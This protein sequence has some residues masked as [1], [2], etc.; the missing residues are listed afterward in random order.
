M[1]RGD[2]GLDPAGQVAAVNARTGAGLTLLGKA[3]HGDSGGALFV[4]WPDGRPG[5][6]TRSPASLERVRQTA[7]VLAALRADGLPVPRHDLI[8]EL[9]GGVVAIV[10]ERL[11][12]RP[13][14]RLDAA[15]IDAM[16]EINERFAGLLAGRADVPV[17]ELGIREECWDPR[18]VALL[19]EHG[20]RARRM[21]DRIREV[22]VSAPLRIDG[23]D[24][25]HPGLTLG[26]VLYEACRVTGVVDWNWGVERGDRRFALVR[27]YIDLYWS[28]VYPGAVEPSAW[29]RLDTV[30]E[31]LIEPD[32]LRAYWAAVTL[33]QLSYWSLEGR[34]EA[35][36]L[37][38]R[39]GESRLTP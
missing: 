7:D 15:A 1:A 9:G 2:G 21:L 37:F 26:N 34:S 12:G 6:L 11:P 32:L 28:L 30:V 18:A 22:G 10:Q 25:L 20:P 13:A 16:V 4:R 35:V 29:E 31:T 36:D 33:G 27:I 24:V 39:L 14:A 19:R 23:D 3:A 17:P 8:V 5:V 38:L